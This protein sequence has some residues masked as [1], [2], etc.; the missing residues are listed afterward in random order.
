MA[1]TNPQHKQVEQE[2]ADI[3][4]QIAD[5]P[6]G[7]STAALDMALKHK[8]EQLRRMEGEQAPDDG[9]KGGKAASRKR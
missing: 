2:I 5:A 9:Q 1:T 3:E 6:E 7:E 4:K 8:Q